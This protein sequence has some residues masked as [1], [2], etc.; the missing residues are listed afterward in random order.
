MQVN[1]DRAPPPPARG[2]DDDVII[3]E[4]LYSYSQWRDGAV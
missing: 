4:S 1:Y 3:N 2:L